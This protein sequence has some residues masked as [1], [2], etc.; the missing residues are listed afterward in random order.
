M[1]DATKKR[2]SQESLNERFVNLEAKVR[3]LEQQMAFLAARL[4]EDELA[5]LERIEGA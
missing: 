4:T 3:R 1:K 5:Q 2:A